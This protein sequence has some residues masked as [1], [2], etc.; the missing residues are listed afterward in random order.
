MQVMEATGVMGRRM[1]LHRRWTVPEE[2]GPA[3]AAE[4]QAMVQVTAH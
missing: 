1:A 4:S 2:A 3:H